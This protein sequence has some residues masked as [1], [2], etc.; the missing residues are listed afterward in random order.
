MTH[1]AKV[2]RIGMG[3]GSALFLIGIVSCTTKVD[4]G[5]VGATAGALSAAQCDYFEVRELP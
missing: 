4:D 5:A 1:R 2:N 3:L